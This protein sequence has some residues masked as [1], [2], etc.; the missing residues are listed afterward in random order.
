MSANLRANII[1]K[2]GCL[3]MFSFVALGARFGHKGQLEEEGQVLF[4][5]GQLYHLT[6]SKNEFNQTWGSLRLV[7]FRARLS[8]SR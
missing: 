1:F 6:N 5:K 7:L 8:H 2:V 3:S 4:Q